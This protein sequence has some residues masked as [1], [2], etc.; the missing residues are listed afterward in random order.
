M[1][2][3]KLDKILTFL[4]SINTRLDTIESKLE[5]FSKRMDNIETNF[6]RMNEKFDD[7]EEKQKLEN[8]TFTEALDSKISKKEFDKL[9]KRMDYIFDQGRKQHLMIDLYNK[10][11]NL[12]IYGFEDNQAWKTKEQSKANI[13]NFLLEALQIDPA[14]IHLVD[15]HRL[16]RHP[17]SFRGKQVTRPIIIKLPK[18]FEKKNNEFI[19]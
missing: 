4:D 18:V 6:D 1:V 13:D 8:K 10:R 16:P 19:A 7:F 2:E 9:A 5:I 12:L 15:V 11:L 3:A 17:I 14:A